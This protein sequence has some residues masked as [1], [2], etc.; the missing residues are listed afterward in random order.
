MRYREKEQNRH[1]AFVYLFFQSVSFFSDSAFN[2]YAHYMCDYIYC[3]LVGSVFAIIHFVRQHIIIYLQITH[4]VW[5]GVLYII[6]SYTVHLKRLVWMRSKM[7]R[8]FL[9]TSCYVISFRHFNDIRITILRQNIKSV[10]G[11]FL[12]F[13]F[14]LF[15]LFLILLNAID[16]YLLHR[17]EFIHISTH[18][19]KPML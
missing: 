7:G 15:H 14:F 2:S 6:L 3:V 18:E 10:L 4:V 8:F 13:L 11:G 16:R 1:D 17:K 5:C 9:S 12:S 19:S